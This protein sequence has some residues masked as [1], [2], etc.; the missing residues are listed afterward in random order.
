M[1]GIAFCRKPPPALARSKLM[2]WALGGSDRR[3][4]DKSADGCRAH[5]VGWM[6]IFV[7][8]ESQR[9]GSIS[10]K[11]RGINNVGASRLRKL[12]AVP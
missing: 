2:R 1:T 5:V 3:W 11:H 12:E 10:E 8:S 9:A 6:G 7:T 4:Q